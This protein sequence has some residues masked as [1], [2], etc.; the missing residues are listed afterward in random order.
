MRLSSE[1]RARLIPLFETRGKD[2]LSRS[3]PNTVLAIPSIA[4]LR[5]AESNER[6]ESTLCVKKSDAVF[7][8]RPAPVFHR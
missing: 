2:N 1:R 7:Y 6:G 8:S 3:P 4:H 5:M